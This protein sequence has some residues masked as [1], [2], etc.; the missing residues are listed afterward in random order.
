MQGFFRA[1]KDGE[2]MP[3]NDIRIICP[4]CGK[5]TT[6]IIREIDYTLREGRYIACMHCNT[7]LEY[8]FNGIRE[9]MRE[10][11]YKRKNGALKQR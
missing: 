6:G 7:K 5:S 9:C 10:R 8:P 2:V 1:L 4:K 11:C 3:D